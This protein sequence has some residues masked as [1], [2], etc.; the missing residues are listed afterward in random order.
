MNSPAIPIPVKRAEPGSEY[1]V[2]YARVLTRYLG[3][4]VIDEKLKVLQIRGSYYDKTE[5]WKAL[6]KLDMTDWTVIDETG[7]KY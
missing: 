7:R 4:R 2:I 6:Y 1:A 5:L 3:G